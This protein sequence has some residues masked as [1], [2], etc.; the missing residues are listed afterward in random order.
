M[1]VKKFMAASMPDAMK[2]I[3]AELG[4]DA[5]ILNSRVVY[6]GG[7]LGFFKKRSIEVMAAADPNQEIEQK[8]AVKPAVIPAAA[9]HFKENTEE[10]PFTGSKTSNELIREIS[11]LKQ[12]MSSLAGGQQISMV[13]PEPVRKVMHVL[14]E[15][16]IDNSIQDQV[17]QVLLEKWYLGGAKAKVTEVEAWLHE[18]LIKQ[19]E[20]IPF[21]GIS[22]TK[23]YINVA[24]PTGVGKTTTLA[25]MAAECVIKHKKKAAFIT[26][27]TYRIAAIDQ[28]KTYAGILDIPLEVC[29]TIDDFRQAAEKLKDYDLVLID[30]AGRNFRNRQY[31]EDLKNVIDFEKDMETFL[32]LSLTA[33]QKDMEDIYNQFSIID[34][35]KLIFTKADETSTYGAMYNIINK[36][37]KGAAYIT[38]GQ[39]VPDDILMAGPEAIVKQLMGNKK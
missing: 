15:Q 20:N 12:M 30:T 21:S 39:D 27:D 29:Y 3:R 37:K 17:L 9:N 1:K 28:L 14:K 18:E 31:V 2:Q 24:G 16:E 23:K 35:D 4:K 10:S 26:A 22:F 25:K 5:V 34:I 13:Y 8:P 33:K 11:S 32:V 6:I 19:I 36:Y 7:F 38:N